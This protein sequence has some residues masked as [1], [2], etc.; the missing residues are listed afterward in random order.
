MALSEFVEQVLERSIRLHHPGYFGHQVGPPLPAAAL[1][2]ALAAFL[3][4]G[5][6]VYEMAPA[7]A[8]ME[9]SLLQWMAD[10]LGLPD[11]SQG[12][13]TSGGSLGNL[14]ALLAARSAFRSRYPQLPASDARLLVSDQAHYSVLR[15]AQVMGLAADQ[16]VSLPTGADYRLTAETLQVTIEKEK[17]AGKLPFVLVA[18]ACSTA[19]G[20]FDPLA[21]LAA[22][23]RQHGLWFHVDAA[24]GAPF[25][26]SPRL[27]S[28]L[29]GIEF[30]DS[31]V[32]D[33][34]KMMM[35]PSLLTA[36]LF[37]EGR[38]AWSSFASEASYL[39]RERAE[40]EWFNLGH[41]TLECTKGMMAMKLFGVL[42]LY[43]EEVL[44]EHLEGRVQQAQAFAQQL[45]SDSEF[46]LALEPQANIVCFRHR[47]PAG[48]DW[49]QHQRDLRRRLIEEGRFFL[50]Q[51]DLGD[52]TYLRCCF[53][54]PRS[55]ASDW[56]ALLERLRLLGNLQ[57]PFF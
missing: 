45:R 26:L 18:N 28:R 27:K 19:T 5:L 46:E 43:G 42:S 6:A 21:A 44:I 53:M 41:R 14:T 20:S 39:F 4:N 38:H 25:C 13:F 1:L 29:D 56:M 2:D 15:A 8:A 17:A 12:L 22:V 35:V 57:H 24:H 10:K 34:H 32:W 54:N 51:T 37:R 47:P 9:W 48:R 23:C 36:V 31:V 40:R 50:V 52:R 3:N 49:N 30:A 16:V 11:T 33:A 55:E 7:G